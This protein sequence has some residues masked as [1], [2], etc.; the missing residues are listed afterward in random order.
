MLGRV[1]NAAVVVFPF[2]SEVFPGASVELVSA[3]VV[4]VAMVVVVVV[5]ACAYVSDAISATAIT[6]AVHRGIK[7]RQLFTLNVS[8]R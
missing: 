8:F 6:E 2:A 7:A 1:V 4:V 3:S 5:I